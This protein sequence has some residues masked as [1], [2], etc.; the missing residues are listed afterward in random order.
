MIVNQPCNSITVSQCGNS[1]TI[2]TNPIPTYVYTT[3]ISGGSGGQSGIQIFNTALQS[4]L[5]LQFISF[6]M[7]FTGIPKVISSINTNFS[8]DIFVQQSSGISTSGFWAI[9]TDTINNSGYSLES[10]ASL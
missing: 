6:P 3:I 9:F 2:N 10:I 4:G 1:L 5:S 8:S 7:T